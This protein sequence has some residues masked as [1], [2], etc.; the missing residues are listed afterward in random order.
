MS[1]A[2]LKKK[3]LNGNPRLAP[4]SGQGIKGF[5]LVGTRRN[6]GGVGQFRMVS[7]VTR[8]RFRGAEPMGNGGCCGSYYNKPSNSGSCCTND[9]SIVKK[10]VKNTAGMIDNKYKWIKSAYPRYWVQDDDGRNTLVGDQGQFISEKTQKNGSCVFSL[11][12]SAYEGYTNNCD[13][14]VACSYHIGGK[15]YIRM[16]YAKQ[17]NH[18]PSQGQYITT[19]G[20]SKNN[21]LPSQPKRQPFPMNLIHD[22]CDTNFRTW[23]QAQAAGLL[24]SDFVAKPTN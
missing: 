14:G 11:P 23:E 15:K 8:T 5:S 4:I 18:T 3:T 20:V 9:P 16:P 13:S 10:T 6:I 12:V 2:V 17:L 1:I 24:P 21:C 19:G 22:G 7:N